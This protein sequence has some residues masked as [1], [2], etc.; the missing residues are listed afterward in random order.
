MTS[1][2]RMAIAAKRAPHTSAIGRPELAGSTEEPRKGPRRNGRMCANAI[3]WG[4]IKGSCI[5]VLPRVSARFRGCC[6]LV[7]A[8]P[9]KGSRRNGRMCANAILSGNLQGSSISI[10]PACF[11]AFPLVLFSDWCGSLYSG[12]LLFDHPICALRSESVHR[13]HHDTQRKCIRRARNDEASLRRR[14]DPG[15]P[16]ISAAACAHRPPCHLF[17]GGRLKLHHAFTSVAGRH[18]CGGTWRHTLPEPR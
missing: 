16:R 1:T 4:N 18:R 6:C 10:F 15:A 8:E 12:L 11:R 13:C 17:S 2:N 5:R 3:L 7:T 14:K 9:R